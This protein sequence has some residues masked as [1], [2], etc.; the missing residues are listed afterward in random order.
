[1]IKH[2]FTPYYSPCLPSHMSF[3]QLGTFCTF[4]FSLYPGTHCGIWQRFCWEHFPKVREKHS[5][6]VFCL[7]QIFWSAALQALCSGW[8]WRKGK[9][10][11][12]KKNKHKLLFLILFSGLFSVGSV[13]ITV[14]TIL[15]TLVKG[16]FGSLWWPIRVV[17]SGGLTPPT[18]HTAFPFPLSLLAPSELLGH[19]GGGIA[20][21]PLSLLCRES[22]RQ[23][24]P[25][26]HCPRLYLVFLSLLLSNFISSFSCIL[27]KQSLFT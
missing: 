25:Q 9:Q 27:A 11:E 19:M 4:P 24:V 14:K 26:L 6:E 18:D 8:V 15:H 20:V 17:R 22:T 16:V 1:M 13:A 21:S 10:E 23:L 12:K 7:T 2:L 3:S 5:L